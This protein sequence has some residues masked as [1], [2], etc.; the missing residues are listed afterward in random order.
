M[1]RVGVEEEMEEMKI[2]ENPPT[3]KEIAVAIRTSKNGKA[4]GIDGIKTEIMKEGIKNIIVRLEKLYTFILEREELPNNCR[5]RKI[6]KL[7]KKG[8]SIQV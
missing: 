3:R 2:D 6:I 7:P 5:K 8:G 4:S 1:R